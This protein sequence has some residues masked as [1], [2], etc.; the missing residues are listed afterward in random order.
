MMQ[1]LLWAIR[2]EGTRERTDCILRPLRVGI[3]VKKKILPSTLGF[4][5]SIKEPP[6]EFLLWLSK[7]ASQGCWGSNRSQSGSSAPQGQGGRSTLGAGRRR[8]YSPL[9]RRPSMFLSILH[10][11]GGVDETPLSPGGQVEN[12]EAGARDRVDRPIP[13]WGWGVGGDFWP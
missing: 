2:E 6:Q 8:T 12:P 9:L 7:E 10:P 13:C 5:V 1:R 4:R 3:D 11:T